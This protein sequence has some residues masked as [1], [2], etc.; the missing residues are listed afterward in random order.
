MPTYRKTTSNEY[1]LIISST[2]LEQ[3][4]SNNRSRVRT[5]MQI[6]SIFARAFNSRVRGRALSNG[7]VL[8]SVDGTSMSLTQ[9][10][11]RTIGTWDRWVSHNNDG[12]KSLPVR[13]EF[14]TITQGTT[15]AF[16]STTVTGTHSLPRIPRGPRV[17]HSGSWRNTILYVRHGGRWRQALIYVRH[18]GK[19]RQAGG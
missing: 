19:W 14:R 4:I 13:A 18:G 6:R 1:E 8:W 10:Q 2:L 11:T 3:D 15:W 17:R 16:P 5:V 9:G 12:T 7:V